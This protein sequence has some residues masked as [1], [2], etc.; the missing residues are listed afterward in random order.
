MYFELLSFVR[1]FLMSYSPRKFERV[2]A[3]SFPLGS[4]MP[5]K[6]S[7]IEIFSHGIK[8][9]L[10][11]Q[12]LTTSSGTVINVVYKSIFNSWQIL[13]AQYVVMI[14]VREA[15][16]HRCLSSLEAKI[17]FLSARMHQLFELT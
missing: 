8:F 7:L 11:P 2:K 6:R 9:A 14:L 3:A 1:L 12:I 4:M 13:Y 17:W 15:I 16:S 10:V 5:Y